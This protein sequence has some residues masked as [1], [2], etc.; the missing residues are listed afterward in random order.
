MMKRRLVSM[1][2]AGA[3]ILSLA[4]CGGSG[5]QTTTTAAT[6][7]AQTEATTAAE[8]TKAEETTTAAEAKTDDGKTYKIGVLQLVQ[9]SALD[10]ANKG[11][12]QALDDAGISYE[13]DQQNAAGEQSTCTTIAEQFVNDKKDLILAIATPAAQAAAAATT[14]IPIILTAV[15]DPADSGLVESNEKPGGNVTGTSDLTPVKEQIELLTRVFPE[16]KK[17]GILYCSAESNSVL[18]ATMAQE[19]C[20]A[21]G[22]EH[23]DYTV[24][25]SNEIQT[26]VE[27]MVGNV[28]VIYAP[29]DNMVAAGMA[30]VAMVATENKLPVVCG[31]SGMVDAGG[32]VTYGVDYYQ[33]GYVAG[34]QAV[35]ILTGKATPAETPIGYMPSD[36]CEL[37][38][39]EDTAA[40]LGLDPATIK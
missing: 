27:S 40:A 9:H 8:T 5:S 28:D 29:T 19:A 35:D 1:M 38:V 7:A 6:T 26:V 12:I 20:D 34:Q 18:Q 31:E 13:A 10:N 39:N 33:I 30:T 24:S 4:G 25:S 23:Q 36:K 21:A 16:A 15:T 14:E 2:M 17:V 11:F 37:K 22:L 32:L 3:M